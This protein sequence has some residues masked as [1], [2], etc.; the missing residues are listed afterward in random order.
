MRDYSRGREGVSR[1]LVLGGTIPVKYIENGVTAI[2]IGGTAV[3]P[4]ISL[5]VPRKKRAQSC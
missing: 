5:L 3:L 4:A 2:R 1:R